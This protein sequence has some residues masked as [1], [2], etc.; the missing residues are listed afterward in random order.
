MRGYMV[1]VLAL[2]LPPAPLPHLPPHSPFSTLS[3][4][5]EQP[6]R[7]HSRFWAPSQDVATSRGGSG[8]GG[9]GDT[10]VIVALATVAGRQE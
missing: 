5:E 2:Q 10:M 9:R 1:V 8:A 7:R 6:M 4:A 3:L